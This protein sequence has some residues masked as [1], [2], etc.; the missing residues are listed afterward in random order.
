LEPASET[1]ARFFGGCAADELSGALPFRLMGAIVM[2]EISST[3]SQ[4]RIVHRLQIIVEY[5]NSSKISEPG[6]C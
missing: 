5:Q 6:G 3:A 2:T 1:R 4:F